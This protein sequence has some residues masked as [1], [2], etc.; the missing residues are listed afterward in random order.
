MPLRVEGNPTNVVTNEGRSRTGTHLS[1]NIYIAVDNGQGPAIVGAVQSLQ[2]S[3][4]RQI[5]KI[6]EVG[7]DGFIDSAPSS[8]TE[9]SGS[10]TRTRFDGV[11]IAQ[12]FRRGFVHVH[13]QREPFDIQ[14][15]DIIQGDEENIIITEIKNVWIKSITY[16]YKADDFIIADEM[17]WDAETIVSQRGNSN[18]GQNAVPQNPQLSLNP[19]ERQADRGFGDYR[20][21]LDAANLLGA[22]DGSGA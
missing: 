6:P 4:A 9:I 7:T 11:R 16:T 18:A 1:T 10:C 5:K 17:T 13:A 15:Y 19:F 20:G 21:A 22:F 2:V 14:I 12:A 8:S 3:E